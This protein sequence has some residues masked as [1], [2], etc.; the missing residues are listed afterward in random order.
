M[1]DPGEAIGGP[2]GDGEPA[3][4]KVNGDTCMNVSRETVESAL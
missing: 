4:S 2:S 3:R 1:S